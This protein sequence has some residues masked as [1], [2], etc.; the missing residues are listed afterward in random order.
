MV[1]KGD[2]LGEIE[3]DKATM[4]L[5]AFEAGVL[6]QILV[7]AVEVVSALCRREREGSIMLAERDT[8]ITL[9]R[10][11]SKE[12]YNIWPVT[13]D[14]YTSELRTR[15]STKRVGHFSLAILLC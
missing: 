15:E 1:Q 10:E 4:D 7:P 3:T 14:L 9:F 6:E 8:L 13:T 11:D 2:I 12:S 5:E